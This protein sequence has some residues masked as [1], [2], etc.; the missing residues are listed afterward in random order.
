MAKKKT[1]TQEVEVQ[2]EAVASTRGRKGGAISILKTATQIGERFGWDVALPVSKKAWLALA[3]QEK[4]A[5]VAE[6]EGL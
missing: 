3:S 5:S 4:L 6:E 1:N 2:T